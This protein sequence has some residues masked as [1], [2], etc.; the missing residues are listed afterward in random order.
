MAIVERERDWLGRLVH[1]KMHHTPQESH[2][3][4][5]WAMRGRGKVAT[6]EQEARLWKPP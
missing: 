1:S 5:G 3:A 6:K 2:E 4:R